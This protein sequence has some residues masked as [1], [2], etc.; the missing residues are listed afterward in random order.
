M[1]TEC[2]ETEQGKKGQSLLQNYNFVVFHTQFQVPKYDFV[3]QI[4]RLWK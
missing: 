2:M 1:T 3:S 4:Q